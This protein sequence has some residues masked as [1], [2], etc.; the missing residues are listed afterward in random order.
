MNNILRKVMLSVILGFLSFT[1]CSSSV[2][3]IPFLS[4]DVLIDVGHG[5]I[6]GGTSHNE[7]LEKDLNLAIAKLLKQSLKEYNILAVLNRTT[8]VAPSDDNHWLPSR[9]RHRRDLAQRSLVM[10][11]LYPKVIISL[12]CNW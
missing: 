12:H 4:P 5:G 1:I 6:D 3:A 8:D 11:G 9:S 2:Q 10:E 7:L